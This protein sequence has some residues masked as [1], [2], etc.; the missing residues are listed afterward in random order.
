MVI[1]VILFDFSPISNTNA[2]DLGSIGELKVAGIER[3]DL[4]NNQNEQ[5]SLSLGD[6]FSSNNEPQLL[7]FLGNVG[8]T[9][10]LNLANNILQESPETIDGS[11][12]ATLYFVAGGSTNLLVDNDISV[13]TSAGTLL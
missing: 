10:S 9:L 5:V 8:D 2:V 11:V 6:I 1:I 4:T 3:V 13:T 7:T 12:D